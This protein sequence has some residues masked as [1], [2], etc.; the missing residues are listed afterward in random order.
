M[1]YIDNNLIPYNY[2]EIIEQAVYTHEE[3]VNQ[4]GLHPMSFANFD[5]D[6]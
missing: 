1:T 2:Q 6:I 5:G 3:W 4:Y